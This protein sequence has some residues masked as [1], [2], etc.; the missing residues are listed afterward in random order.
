M[1]TRRVGDHAPLSKLVLTDPISEGE[2]SIGCTANLEG[3]F[4]LEVFGF[5]VEIEVE[6]FRKCITR[7]HWGSNHLLSE[8]LG[9]LANVVD[10][11]AE[12][13]HLCHVGLCLSSGVGG[14][15]ARS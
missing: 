2:Y 6:C 3:T 13:M 4:V 10:G 8:T 14:E 7:N 11:N 12:G 1:V 9:C 15:V 5:E